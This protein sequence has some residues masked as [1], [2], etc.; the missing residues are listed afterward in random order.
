MLL[1]VP[2]VMTPEQ[3]AECR[4]IIDGAPWV[5]GRV[6]AGYQATTVK[7]N[8]Q[9]AENHPL[10]R[11]ASDLVLKA[12]QRTTLFMSAALPYKVYP[13]MFNRYRSGETFGT[14]I[15]TAIRSVPDTPY[16]V[17]TDLSVTLFLNDPSEYDGGELIIEDTYGAHRVKLPPGDLVLYPGSSLHHV[18]PITRGERIASFFWLQSMVR[19]D[20]KRTIL[21]DMDNSIQQLARA[22]PNHKALI[23]LTGVYHNL[24]R[25]WA[26]V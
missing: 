13:P 21:F 9:V 12:L 8:E 2:N 26:E 14:H 16:R 18:T 6:T 24:L 17:R 22:V 23:Q 10:A 11:Q 25:Q 3:V 7:K 15:D 5:D 20:A 19:D 4:R 1:H